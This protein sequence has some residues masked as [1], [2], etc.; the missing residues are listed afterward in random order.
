M[1]SANSPAD[2]KYLNGLN[3]P[4]TSPTKIIQ[5]ADLINQNSKLL[6]SDKHADTFGPKNSVYWWKLQCCAPG[7]EGGKTNLN[8]NLA[9]T[10]SYLIAWR[11]KHDTLIEASLL[12][13][14]IFDQ[15]KLKITNWWWTR[16]HVW[17]KEFCL[18]MK[19][20]M[21]RPKGSRKGVGPNV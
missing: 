12:L 7:R 4:M 6:T 17:A 16:R 13:I 3:K 1:N 11:R 2:T 10:T 14:N 15:S 19:I 18:L 9:D 20:T 5:M 8:M 21:L